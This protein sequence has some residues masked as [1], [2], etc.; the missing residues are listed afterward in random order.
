MWRVAFMAAVLAGTAVPAGA[1]DFVVTNCSPVEVT[2]STYNT[3][4]PVRMVPARMAILAPNV[5]APVGCATAGCIL[6]YAMAPRGSGLYERPS[7]RDLCF[8]GWVDW[9]GMGQAQFVE[10]NCSVG[11]D[12]PY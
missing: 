5:T 8:R 11:C 2:I 7:S 9:K 1:V 10:E 6:A 3:D 12:Q 4:D